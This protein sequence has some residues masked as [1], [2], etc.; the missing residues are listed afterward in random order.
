VV[1]RMAPGEL[2]RGHG[3][4]E[5]LPDWAASII[6]IAVGLCPGLAVLSARSIALLIHRV[7]WPETG[8]APQLGSEPG[9]EEAG[10]ARPPM[11][12]AGLGVRYDDFPIA[13]C[14]SASGTLRPWIG[15][16]WSTARLSRSMLSYRF[17][18]AGLGCAGGVALGGA[19]VNTSA[20][21]RS[22]SLGR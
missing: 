18:G 5:T 8:R 14:S 6:A 12:R 21:T 9:G 10:R 2:Y 20:S 13:F 7:S 11:L 16:I 22:F 17:T 15:R 4:L 1:R 3:V 19:G